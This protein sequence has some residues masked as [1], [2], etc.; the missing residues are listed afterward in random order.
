[1]V[2]ILSIATRVLAAGSGSPPAARITQ[3]QG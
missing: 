1:V 3:F 2:A